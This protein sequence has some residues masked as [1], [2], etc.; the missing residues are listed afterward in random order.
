MNLKK[1]VSGT[2]LIVFLLA[3]AYLQWAAHRKLPN[4]GSFSMQT[5]G[6]GGPAPDFELPVLDGPAVSLQD[7]RGRFVLLDFWAT[8]CGPCRQS[9]PLLEELQNEH[10]DELVLLAINLN[11]SDEA[12]RQFLDREGLNVTVLMDRDGAVGRAYGVTGIPTQVLINPQGETAYRLV[13]FNSMM[14]PNFKRI[15]EKNREAD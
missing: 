13:G 15:I 4:A 8:W 11:E 10:R 7:F 2:L 6:M 12:V 1:A 3:S 9:M 5:M 14:I